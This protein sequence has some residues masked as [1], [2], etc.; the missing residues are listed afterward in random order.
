MRLAG[1]KSS[2]GLRLRAALCAAIVL[3]FVTCGLASPARAVVWG[4]PDGN[5]HPNVGVIFGL[6]DQGFS[7]YSCTGTLIDPVTVLTAAHCVGGED[8]G[9]PI[10][11]IVIDFDASLPLLPNGYYLISRSVE[12][13]GD[14]NPA[15]QDVHS[16]QPGTGGVA[17]FLA[18]QAFD[19]G[20]LHLKAPANTVFPGIQPAP[21]VG[22]NAIE[23][24]R[25]GP[26]NAQVLQVGY[27]AQRNG[28]PGQAD[29]YFIDYTRNR[30]LSV[31]S[32]VTD[33]LLVVN[34]NPNNTAGYGTPCSGD[35]GSPMFFDG[36]IAGV[37]SYAGG[38]CQNTG[39]GAR[40][41]AG[42]GRTFLA[43][44]GLLS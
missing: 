21:I 28:P 9:T 23:R 32:K 34:A 11:R 4:E 10:A 36:V 19:V 6:N 8:F 20:L 44:R 14:P 29:S 5:D 38:N 3:A 30:S 26:K 17:G 42:P 18:N 40:L 22:A 33:A 12:G 37:F 2:S 41:D 25:S 24:N 35:S 13:V 31:L 15:Y 39:G 43:S 7:V 27:G 16:P 1:R